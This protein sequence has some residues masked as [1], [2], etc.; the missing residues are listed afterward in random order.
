MLVV[1]FIPL[2]SLAPPV[3]AQGD[4]CDPSLLGELDGLL[5]Q[6]QAALDNG[7]VTTAK[8]ILSGI[9][10]TIAPCTAGASSSVQAPVAEPRTSVSHNGDWTPVIREFDGVEMVLVPAGCFEM[11]SAIGSDR[12]VPV[13]QQCIDEPFWIDRYEVTNA[14][15]HFTNPA[16][17]ND[18]L[19]RVQVTW[20]DAW[21]F[22]KLRDGELRLPTEAQWEYAARGPDGLTFP[23]GNEFVK[24]NLAYRGS[25]NHTVEVNSYPNGVSWVGAFNMSGNVLE[26]T[27]T[28]Y[29]D[30]PYDANDGREL[31]TAGTHVLRGGSINEDEFDQRSAARLGA[32]AGNMNFNI[33]FRCARPYTGTP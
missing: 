27:S 33:G 20:V 1:L 16:W 19:P 9:R 28:L 6:A 31:L 26:W 22:C 14:Q 25:V 4:S 32:D 2:L 12:E 17:A 11:G 18:I 21:E 7:N 15:Y 30:Y 29:R 24:D 10:A 8:V 3:S 23:W 5:A 13:T